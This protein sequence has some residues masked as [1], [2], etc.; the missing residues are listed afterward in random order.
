MKQF[1]QIQAPTDVDEEDMF[2][3]KDPAPDKVAPGPGVAI[4]KGTPEAAELNDFFATD[5]VNNE[6]GFSDEEEGA[7]MM[8]RAVKTLEHCVDKV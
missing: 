2:S 1:E 6:S 3:Y 5:V 8:R 4:K 7:D